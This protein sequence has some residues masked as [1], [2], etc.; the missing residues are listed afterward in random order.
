M[1]TELER[2]TERERFEHELINRRLTWLLTSQSLLFAAFG[3][4]LRAEKLTEFTKVFLRATTLTGISIAAFIWIGVVAGIFAK[5]TAW[6]DY[7]R[8]HDAKAQLCLRNWITYS[9]LAP[10][11]FMPIVFALAWIFINYQTRT[12]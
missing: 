10:D 9:A 1:P 11:V 2:F 3:V 12:L 7:K 4:A 8:D 6:R 5:V